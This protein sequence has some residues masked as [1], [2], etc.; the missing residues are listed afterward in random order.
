MKV[1]SNTATDKLINENSFPLIVKAA[2]I[3]IRRRK[4]WDEGPMIEPSVFHLSGRKHKEARHGE[5]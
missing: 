4:E 1:V 2:I 3:E 5:A